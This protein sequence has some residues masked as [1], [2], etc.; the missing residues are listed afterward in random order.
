MNIR[1]LPILV[2][3]LLPGAVAS[4]LGAQGYPTTPPPAGQIRPAVFPP[5]QEER[6]PNGLTLLLV[7]NHR[8]PVVSISL[9]IPAG[10][11]FD[12]AGK[13]GTAGL[14]AGLL[15]KGA[16][17]RSAEQIAEA[18]ER[19]G[20]SIGAGAGNETL[21][22]RADVL[23]PDVGLAFELLG[24]ALTAPDFP[25]EELELLRTQT[26]SGLQL[27]L[28]QPASIAQRQFDR[29][30]YGDHPFGRAPTPGTVQAI[31]REDL[32]AF[33]RDRVRPEGSLL[34]IA[35]ALTMAEAG[36][37]AGDAF[38][39]WTGSPVG[40]AAFPSP[41]ARTAR[42]IVLVH[43]PGS[44]QSNILIGNLTFPPTDTA[45]YA[46]AL[47]NQI[48]GGGTDSRLFMILREEKGWTYGAY[49][50]VIRRQNMGAFRA[51]AEVRTEVTD[52]A[53]GEMLNQFN[54]LRTERVTGEEL[55]A[56]KGALVG[57]FPLSIETANQVAGAVAN[58]RLLGLPPDYLST[59]RTRLAAVDE[60]SLQR[61]AVRLIRP[62]ASLVVVV[63]DATKVLETVERF[64]PVR[65]LSPTGEPI[66]R[67]DLFGPATRLPV[68]LSLMAARSD[69]FAILLQG[70]PLGG[71]RISLER[72]DS[73]FRYHEQMSIAG[74]VSQQ[75]DVAI[76]ASGRTTAV[77]Q[78][79]E[80]QGQPTSV[81]VRYGDGRATGSAATVD[82]AAG[83]K[84]VTVDTTVSDEAIDDNALYAFLPTLPWGTGTRWSFP[85]FNAAE[86][87]ESTLTLAV[88]T[89][90]S[91]TVPAGT[92]EAYRA[93]LTGGEA[94]FTIW[95]STSAPHRILKVALVGQPIE[96]VLVP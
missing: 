92:F 6:L 78:S 56:A 70:M 83:P 4:P 64:G 39:Q 38:R 80:L 37:L 28:S 87:S 42:D 7:E 54:R 15:T 96:F 43:R 67:E 44:V 77:K 71:Q 16:G 31:D 95:V 51:S 73:G 8:Q 50:S 88:T 66:T 81:D 90:E 9:A 21:T 75:T 13:E 60:G 61:A 19:V 24:A 79:G 26:L 91:L 74:I 68:D 14:V 72:T 86:A 33:H 47:A 93:D 76:D 53:L 25:A 27:E 46:A 65:M 36:K 94:P 3:V 1:S 34:V 29:A 82:P 63:G 45:S 23:A 69:S 57:R 55:D 12:P 62:D 30:L 18:I 48:L 89:T 17:G 40:V 49:S 2:L 52:S 59:Y 85:V 5:F 20:G 41:P 35:G 22:L 58:A 11:A 32:V 10:T 84:T